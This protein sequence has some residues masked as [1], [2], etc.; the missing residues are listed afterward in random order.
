MTPK[1]D[2]RPPY[3]CAYANIPIHTHSKQKKAKK[4]SREGQ[5]KRGQEKG[6]EGR[7]DE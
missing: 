3:T 5:R 1:V 4:R 6:G 7:M 2:L